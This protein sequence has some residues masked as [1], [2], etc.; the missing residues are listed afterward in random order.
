[1]IRD[2]LVNHKPRLLAELARGISGGRA[3]IGDAT[4]KAE[5]SDAAAQGAHRVSVGA[6]VQLRLILQQDDGLR[7]ETILAIPKDRYDGIRV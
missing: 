5:K 4:R 1:M 2:L 7:I 3:R 6:V